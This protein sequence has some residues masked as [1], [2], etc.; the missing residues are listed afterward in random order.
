MRL[1]GLAVWR[2]VALVFLLGAGLAFAQAST[3][4]INGRVLDQG[5]AVLPG[6]T[7]TVTNQA[8][9][10]VRT[11]VSNAE[12][13]YSMPGLDPGVYNVTTDLTGF[14]AGARN[15]VTLTA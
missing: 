7:V 10:V 5:D 12:G 11:T 2:L 4:T 3:G 15:G 9:G 1:F 6:V 14:A 13:V 8:T